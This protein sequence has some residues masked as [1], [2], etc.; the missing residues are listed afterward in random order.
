MRPTAAGQGGAGAGCS[1]GYFPIFCSVSASAAVTGSCTTSCHFARIQHCKSCTARLAVQG[2]CCRT[3]NP[4]CGGWQ[5][6]SV[7]SAVAPGQGSKAQMK[8]QQQPSFMA[9]HRHILLDALQPTQLPALLLCM[10]RCLLGLVLHNLGCA[11]SNTPL[12]APLL[13]TLLQSR[14]VF[15]LRWC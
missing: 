11:A 3:T 13:A 1:R 2:Q 5:Q 12:V 6:H 4:R 8:S 7:G 10:S 15:C 9:C 14:A